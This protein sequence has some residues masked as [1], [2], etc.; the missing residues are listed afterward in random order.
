MRLYFKPHY[1]FKGNDWGKH[2]KVLAEYYFMKLRNKWVKKVNPLI[3]G[4]NEDFKSYFPDCDLTKDK[5]LKF[6]NSFMAGMLNIHVQVGNWVFRGEC[7][8]ETGDFRLIYRLKENMWVDYD[9]E[10][11][12]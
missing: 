12:D 5:D 3:K 11:C 10:I 9:M 7:N 8:P 6:Y 4:I 2:E 1:Y